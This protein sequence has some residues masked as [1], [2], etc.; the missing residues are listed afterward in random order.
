VVALAKTGDGGH[1][2]H[3]SVAAMRPAR[4]MAL[5]VAAGF[6]VCF[7]GLRE[8]HQFSGSDDHLH[9][10]GG[11]PQAP[12]IHTQKVQ[13]QR[14][15]AHVVPVQRAEESQQEKY[16]AHRPEDMVGHNAIAAVLANQ[17][18]SATAQRMMYWNRGPGSRVTTAYKSVM[19]PPRPGKVSSFIFRRR[20][21]SMHTC[22]RCAFQCTSCDTSS[23]PAKLSWHT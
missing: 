14:E 7:V 4:A 8:L 5:V 3:Q 19:P 1:R 20:E 17:A 9:G 2:D 21:N 6:G 22:T 15:G 13:Q 18:R 12:G 10:D 23:Y 16:V 11:H